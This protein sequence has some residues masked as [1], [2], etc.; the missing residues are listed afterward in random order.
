[1]LFEFDDLTNQKAKLKVI[2]VGGGGGNAINRMIESGLT[3]VD[4]IAINTDAQDL[5]NNLSPAKIQIGKDL[6]RGLGAG[7]VKE[8]GKMAMEADRQPTINSINGADMVFITAGMGGGTGTGASPLI[9]KLSKEQGCL[10]VGIVT[11]PFH[12]EGPKRMQR[13]EEGI[14]ELRDSVDTLIVIPNQRL[15]SIVDRKTSIR[16]AF[17]TAD[18]VLYQATKGIS[19]LINRHGII[20]LDFADI[21]TI[22]KNMGDA[23]MGTGLATGEERAVLAAQQ[24]ISSPLLNDMNIRGANGLLINVTGG[25]DLNL[26]EVDEA[27]KIITEEAGNDADIIIGAVID[28][29]LSDEIMI[30]VIATGFGNNNRSTHRNSDSIIISTKEELFAEEISSA[31]E[32]ENNENTAIEDELIAEPALKI[33][34]EDDEK[35]FIENVTDM[36]DKNIPAILRKMM[37]R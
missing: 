5:D 12:F 35:S 18:S 33:S 15:L 6:T 17:Q 19:D 4:F 24:A 9:A 8:I 26:F 28:E 11:K 14:R 7:A 23:I 37:K 16:Q 36:N 20:N 25:E 13:A 21:K 30:T 31:R 34:F 32:Y 22:M 3:G 1:M 10:T 27:C 29:K 2:G